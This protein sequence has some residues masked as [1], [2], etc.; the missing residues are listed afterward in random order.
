M[1]NNPDLIP[2]LVNHSLQQLI[3]TTANIPPIIDALAFIDLM[4]RNPS[5]GLVT[6]A[7]A[8]K[9]AGQKKAQESHFILLGMQKSVRE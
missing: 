9:G 1:P 4:C 2:T 5:L 7:R 3:A 6:K 8:C